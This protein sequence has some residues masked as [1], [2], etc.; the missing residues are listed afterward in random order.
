MSEFP[1]MPPNIEKLFEMYWVAGDDRSTAEIAKD[2]GVTPRTIQRYAKKYGWVEL[3]EAREAAALR[4]V[5]RAV[6]EADQEAQ[7]Q[8][9]I[10][11]VAYNKMLS[12]LVNHGMENFRMGKIKAK[13]VADLERIHKMYMDNQ[14]FLKEDGRGNSAGVDNMASLADAIRSGM[15]HIKPPETESKDEQMFG[16]VKEE[17]NRMNGNR[18]VN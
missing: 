14:R 11:A 10:E 13:S 2:Q 9:I 7:S 1:K 16:Y 3:V 6:K 17:E 8:A 18:R 12:E 5:K 4:G 15:G